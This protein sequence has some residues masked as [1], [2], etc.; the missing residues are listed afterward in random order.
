MTRGG[1][2]WRV[3]CQHGSG[4]GHSMIRLGHGGTLM[5]GLGLGGTD[6]V[7]TCDGTSGLLNHGLGGTPESTL[8]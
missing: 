7:T 4:H 5:T 2:K 8:G 1:Q 6:G 3:T